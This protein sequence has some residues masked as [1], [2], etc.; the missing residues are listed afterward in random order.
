M[1]CVVL[2]VAV[3]LVSFIWVLVRFRYSAGLL[4]VSVTVCR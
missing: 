1:C 4:G 3:Y 2:L